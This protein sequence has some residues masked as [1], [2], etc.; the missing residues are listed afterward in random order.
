MRQKYKMI[1][2]GEKMD[3]NTF[4]HLSL[5]SFPFTMIMK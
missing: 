1:D 2:E 4:V 5:L 3:L